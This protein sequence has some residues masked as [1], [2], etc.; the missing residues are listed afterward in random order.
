MTKCLVVMMLNVEVY[1]YVLKLMWF[2]LWT[3]QR[4]HIILFMVFYVPT[5]VDLIFLE[6]LDYIFL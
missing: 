6:K 2:G 1:P 4:I 5:L 3:S